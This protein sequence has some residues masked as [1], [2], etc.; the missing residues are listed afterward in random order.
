MLSSPHHAGAGRHQL[1]RSAALQELPPIA[2]AGVPK[3]AAT[4]WYGVLA[5]KDTCATGIQRI[6]S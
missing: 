6:N 5:P 1:N 2:K 4:S 3:S